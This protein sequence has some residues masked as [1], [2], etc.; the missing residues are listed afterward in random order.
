M[1]RNTVPVKPQLIVWARERA[2]LDQEAL[3]DRFPKIQDWENGE[4]KP[5]LRQLENFAK[6]VHV[7]IGYLFLQEPIS[8]P[9]PISDF[10]T[11]ADKAVAQP[12]PNLLDTIYLCQERQTWYRE[13][14]QLHALQPLSFIGSASIEKNPMEVA[15]SMESLLGTS[16]E[17]RTK[18][19]SWTETL[20]FLVSRM[21]EA[22]V[23]VMASSIVGSNT[24]RH[25][26]AKE[27]RGLALADSYAPLIFLNTNDS[28]AAQMFTLVHEFAHILLGE[29]GIS[30]VGVEKISDVA[31]ERWCNAVAA[32]FLMPMQNTL[33]LFQKGIP[34]LEEIQR[35]AKY[36]KVSSLVA[37]RRLFDARLIDTQVFWKVYEEEMD[38]ISKLK[39]EESQGG[40]FY[41]TLGVRVGK[42]FAIAVMTSTLEGQTLFRDAFHMLGF[43]KNETFYNEARE[44]G[45]IT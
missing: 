5:T 39:S 41:R 9:L 25:L 33:E 32:E 1:S 35:L 40:N 16:H 23:L 24:H 6:A 17:D 29:S 22:G 30:D 4:I 18:L 26:D 15:K 38:R 2:K 44:L 11:F 37:L 12:S 27:F 36:F 28:K 31:T 3:V 42:R 20:R 43:K 8:E 7:P 34:L 10:R 45:L 14:M 19:P 13:Y 21:E